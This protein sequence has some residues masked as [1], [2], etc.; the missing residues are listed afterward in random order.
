MASFDY[1]LAYGTHASPADGRCA[2]EWVS[3]L[4]GEPHSDQPECVSPVLRVFCIALND[5]LEDEPRQRLRPYLARTIGTAGDGQDPRR[6]WMALDWLIRTF[7]PAWLALADEAANALVLAAL[8][9]VTDP[10]SLDAALAP[11]GRARAQLRAVRS[12]VS[13]RCPALGVPWDAVRGAARETAWSC[14]GAAAWS[15]ARLAIGESAGDRARAL[16]QSAAG[17]AAAAAARAA[18]SH[19]SV[20]GG[21]SAHRAATRAVLAPTLSA[22]RVSVLELLERM[23]PLETVEIPAPVPVFTT[24]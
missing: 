12:P 16:A 13:V 10:A 22:L 17:D 4:A 1:A 3:H 6:A 11:L 19:D 5:G 7:T 18:L 23:L 24:S 14:A 2:M 9:P 15:A 8:A 21:R 20:T